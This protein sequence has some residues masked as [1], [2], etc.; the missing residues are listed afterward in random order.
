MNANKSS[1]LRVVVDVSFSLAITS[2]LVLLYLK[3]VSSGPDGRL[4]WEAAFFF[5][6]AAV[7][8]LAKEYA[9]RSSLLR[10]VRWIY[11]TISFPRGPYMAFVYAFVFGAVGVVQLYRWLTP[12]G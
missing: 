12:G 2:F 10:L 9:N 8:L 3:A 5:A 1:T 11:E 4:F 6:L 7:F